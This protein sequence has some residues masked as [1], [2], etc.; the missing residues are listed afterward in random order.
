[1]I[2]WLFEQ[3]IVLSIIAATL[4]FVG[5]TCQSFL[6]AK[7]L[8]KLWWTM[9]GALLLSALP[10]FPAAAGDINVWVVTLAHSSQVITRELD[11]SPLILTTLW[12]MGILILGSYYLYQ[13]QLYLKQLD[14]KPSQLRQQTFNPGLNTELQKVQLFRS[15]HI[16]SAFITGLF[17]AY[18]VLPTDFEIRFSQQQQQ[19]IL[20]HELTHK[21]HG[22]LFWN[23]L[24]QLLVLAFW[25]NPLMWLAVKYFRQ[26]QELA[27]DQAV[28][29]HSNKSTRI[30]YARAMLLCAEQ[31]LKINKIILNYGDKSDMQLRLNQLKQHKKH[32]VWKSIVAIGLSLCA[33]LSVQT[34]LAHS[35]KGHEP[36]PVMRI[37]PVYPQDA[38]KEGIEGSVVLAFDIEKDGSTS[39]I[40]VVDAKPEGIFG[41][42]AITAM[43]QWRWTAS[44][45]KSK[46]MKVQL[47]FVLDKKRL[48]PRLAAT[49]A[50]DEQIIV[51]N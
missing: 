25:F 18:L 6:D 35:N 2:S 32:Q 15:S 46:N 40:K 39:N 5:K 26:T 23:L 29:A 13:H 27:C 11:Q 50:E 10:D 14:L 4:I 1:M 17:K 51:S 21:R 30:A 41:Q 48:K 3:S 19:L 33:V 16:G 49:A 9:P 34:S 37:E 31:Q 24:A 47:D 7:V 38:A 42:A 12:V 36:S 22:D 20:Q 45:H 8:Y 28:L 43:K 44:D